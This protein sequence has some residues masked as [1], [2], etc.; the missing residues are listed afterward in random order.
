MARGRSAGLLTREAQRHLGLL[1][2]ALTEA[3][4]VT[5][6]ITIH[7]PALT[8]AKQLR[9]RDHQQRVATALVTIIFECV[10]CRAA[11]DR[12]LVL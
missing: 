11:E 5:G 3:V 4:K 12:L 2:P 1:G 9:E 6:L 10:R 8:S 7:L